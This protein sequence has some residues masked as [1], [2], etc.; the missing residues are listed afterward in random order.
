MSKIAQVKAREI[1][2]SRGH[3]T[4]ETTV[5]LDSGEYGVASVPTGIST[6]KDEAKQLRDGDP[7]RYAGLGVLKAVEKVTTV[8]AGVIMGKE[9]GQQAQIDKAMLDLDATT[10]KSN[11]GANSILSVSIAA[12]K[13]AARQYR[14]P[15]YKYI[16][17]LLGRDMNAPFTMPTPMFNVINGG[18]HGAGNLD[19]QEFLVVP[20]HSIPYV[21]TV[22]MGAEIYY[23]LLEV[24]KHRNAIYSVGDE[25]GF[26]PN[27]FTNADALEVITQAIMAT[28]YKLGENV[29]LGLDVAASHFHQGNDYVIKDR[30]TPL[31]RSDMVGYFQELIQQYHLLSLEDPIAEDDFDGWK[32]ITVALGS[33]TMIVGDDFLVTN[34]KHLEQAVAQNAAN[35]IIIKPNQIGTLTETLQVVYNAQKAKWRIVTSHRSGETNDDFIADFAVGIDSN[36]AKFGAPARGERVAK[37]N[38]LL[39]IAAAVEGK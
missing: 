4:I 18:K 2:D 37:Y 36:Y 10:D 24:L 9:A 5:V 14:L 23:A 25:G 6:G 7:T 15:V 3:P 11:L 20:G 33:S 1:L 35:A 38:R 27:L 34:M 12:C 16:R 32:E 8:I 30:T 13:A 39:A 17:A 19:F 31:S 22:E 21:Q 26:A 29:F 28:E